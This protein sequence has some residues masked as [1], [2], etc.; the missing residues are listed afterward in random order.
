MSN[1]P[2]QSLYTYED[3]LQRDQYFQDSVH[4]LNEINIIV[5]CSYAELD[6]CNS[7]IYIYDWSYADQVL[8]HISIDP[9]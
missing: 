2:P 7:Y 5:V 4:M 8:L 6:S 1:A 9:V 3:W